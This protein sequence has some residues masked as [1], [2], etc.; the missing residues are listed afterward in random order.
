MLYPELEQK[1]QDSKNLVNSSNSKNIIDH[2]KSYLALLAEYRTTLYDLKTQRLAEPQS[3]P[4][5]PEK[6]EDRAEIRKAIE[7]TTLERNRT[8]VLLLSFTTVS[9]YEAVALFNERTY[10]GHDDWE[11]QASGIKFRGGSDGALMSIQEAVELAS[12]LRREDYIQQNSQR[13]DYD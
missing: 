12:L 2:C 3:R 11:L 4:R 10:K 8:E 6:I 5:L 13:D 9:G 1:L 7:N